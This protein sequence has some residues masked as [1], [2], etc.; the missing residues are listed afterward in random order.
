[1]SQL[2]FYRPLEYSR[3]CG[4]A[5][6]TDTIFVQRSYIVIFRTWNPRLEACLSL[7]VSMVAAGCWRRHWAWKN[8]TFSQTQRN[9]ARM[10]NSARTSVRL[11]CLLSQ[12]WSSS[13][14]PRDFFFSRSPKSIPVGNLTLFCP[15]FSLVEIKI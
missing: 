3:K 2:R 4:E 11:L 14:N 5:K 8:Y 15:H 10:C 12:T 7:E 13:V 6:A 9:L 1:M